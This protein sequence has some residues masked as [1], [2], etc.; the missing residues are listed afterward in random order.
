MI[1]ASSDPW[2]QRVHIDAR[3]LAAQP[4]QSLVDGDPRQPG[5]E[6]EVATETF[7]MRERPDIGFLDHVLGFAVVAQDAAREPV[8][9]AIVRLHDRAD[10]GLVA[11][12]GALDQFGF[13]AAGGD[14][15][16]LRLAH[17]DFH[18][19]PGFPDRMLS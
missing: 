1:W 9:P 14:L 12:A 4:A 16:Y 11:V 18:G 13:R 15:R 7:E 17:G 19:G 8:E 5:R 3:P 2:S 6:A 10:R